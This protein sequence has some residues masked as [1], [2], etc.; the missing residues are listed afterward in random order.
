MRSIR[1]LAYAFAPLAS[2]L[3]FGILL[4]RLGVL[5]GTWFVIIVLIGLVVSIANAVILS[6]GVMKR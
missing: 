4:V 3:L 1:A 2:T 6:L 5:G